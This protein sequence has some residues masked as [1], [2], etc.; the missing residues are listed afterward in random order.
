M[1]R[2]IRKNPDKLTERMPV[3]SEIEQRS[4]IG[5]VAPMSNP[6]NPFSYSDAMNMIGI[7]KNWTISANDSR[8]IT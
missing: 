6:D 5:E 7:S 1:K 3:I 2:L 4:H 8:Y